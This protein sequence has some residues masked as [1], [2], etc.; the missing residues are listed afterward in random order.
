MPIMLHV[1]P[2][3]ECTW[4]DFR[5][6]K[7]PY[8]I[9]LDG[10]VDDSTA[11]DLSGPYAN[12]DHHRGSDSIGTRSTCEQ[13]HLAITTGLFDLFKKDGEPHAHVFVNHPDADS[14]LSWW[15][16]KNHELVTGDPK[17][18]ISRLSYFEDMLD[19]TSG[20]YPFE[21]THMIRKIAWIFEPYNNAR[22]KG[23]LDHISGDEMRALIECIG[24]RIDD[25]VVGKEKELSLE[26]HYEIIGGGPGWKMTKETG[27]ASRIAMHHDGIRAYVTLLSEKDGWYFYA[28]GRSP[29]IEFPLPALYQKFNEIE[30]GIVTE[31]N[32][33]NG[34]DNRGGPPKLTGSRLPPKKLEEIINSE[35]LKIRG[36]K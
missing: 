31:S 25:Y 21:E 22:V 29:W 18:S 3:K 9:A 8:S 12:F 14:T 13:V 4:D 28:M 36:G 1:E 17:I 27:P 35:M 2:G 10:F 6:K 30:K 15:E 5:K 24:Y 7:P 16:L 23:E 26:G 32:K 19:C 33:W 11:R 20:D 34:G